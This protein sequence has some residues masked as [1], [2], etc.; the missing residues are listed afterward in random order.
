MFS[1][2]S[3]RKVFLLACVCMFFGMFVVYSMDDNPEAEI[4]AVT[5]EELRQINEQFIQA[6]ADFEKELPALEVLKG[7]FD[8]FLKDVDLHD[9]GLFKSFRNKVL[10]SF[11]ADSDMKIGLY[12]AD[13]IKFLFLVSSIYL[14]KILF[15][16]LIDYYNKRIYRF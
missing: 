3:I 16:Q 7:E 2:I 13:V 14:D 8:N 15:D 1:E 10:F 6:K 4:P 5:T 12:G 9:T 11:P